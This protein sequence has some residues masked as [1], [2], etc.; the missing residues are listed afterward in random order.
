MTVFFFTLKRPCCCIITGK[1][2]NRGL[3]CLEKHSFFFLS[4]ICAK[5][6]RFEWFNQKISSSS[7]TDTSM[8]LSMR[9]VTKLS[10]YVSVV[11][12]CGQLFWSR[13][14]S[15]HK[16]P[17]VI[18]VVTHTIEFVCLCKRFVSPLFF[19]SP[20]AAVFALISALEAVQGRVHIFSNDPDCF[21]FAAVFQRLVSVCMWVCSVLVKNLV[22]FL[23]VFLETS[24]PVCTSCLCLLNFI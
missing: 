10:K 21:Q 13:Q 11:T 7:L 6:H 20:R 3:A 1:A 18:S 9:V 19:L 8:L 16:W 24:I 17:Y 22:V 4:F 23:F 15:N 2:L 5:R 14:A 12:S